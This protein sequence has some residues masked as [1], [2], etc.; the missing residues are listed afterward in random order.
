MSVDGGRPR[1]LLDTSECYPS[2]CGIT[3]PP[4]AYPDHS[5]QVVCRQSRNHSAAL[6]LVFGWVIDLLDDQDLHRSF[7][8]PQR[9]TEL[10]FEQRLER[11]HRLR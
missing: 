7:G 10:R 5:F 3:L 1:L 6:S 4:P 9:E 8:R 11:T 2:A